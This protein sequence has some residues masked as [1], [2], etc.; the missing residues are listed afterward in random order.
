MIGLDTNILVRYIV[1]DDSKQSTLATQ[2]IERK[3]SLT[4]PGFISLV[5]LIETVWVLRSCYQQSRSEIIALLRLIITIRQLRVEKLEIV[6][7]A[8][9]RFE[10]GNGDFSD[11]VICLVNDDHGCDETIT[12]DKKARTVGMTLLI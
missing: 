8:I 6:H 1:Q 3:L 11:A 12:F 5:T 9:K 7:Q 2:L 10:H 4:N